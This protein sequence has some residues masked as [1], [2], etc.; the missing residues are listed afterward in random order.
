MLASKMQLK[1]VDIENIFM[2]H[3]DVKQ[4]PNQY[5]VTYLIVTSSQKNGCTWSQNILLLLLLTY[6]GSLFLG[7]AQ[8]CFANF[9]GSSVY[10]LYLIIRYL[11]HQS[12]I[13]EFCS[14]IFKKVECLGVKLAKPVARAYA[15]Y[16]VE[17]AKGSTL[18]SYPLPFLLPTM[19]L[20]MATK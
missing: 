5:K 9:F 19:R 4:V 13:R 17:R 3:L 1:M 7:A 14:L 10:Q 12:D 6:S 11:A 18:L 15:V 8:P 16:H 2:L 20:Y